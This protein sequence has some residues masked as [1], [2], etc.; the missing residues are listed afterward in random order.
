MTTGDVKMAMHDMKTA[1]IY[2]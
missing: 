1:A 2:I